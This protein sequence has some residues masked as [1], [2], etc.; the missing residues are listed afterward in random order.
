[1]R[2]HDSDFPMKEIDITKLR[3]FDID[4]WRKNPTPLSNC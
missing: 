2:M 1:M 3:P 4:E